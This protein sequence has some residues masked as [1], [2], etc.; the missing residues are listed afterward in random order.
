MTISESITT[1]RNEAERLN[2]DLQNMDDEDLIIR[3]LAH[4]E[5]DLEDEFNEIEPEIS[6]TY[7]EYYNNFHELKGK[8][9]I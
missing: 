1:L 6:M 3:A 8:D 7:E 4:L 9:A 5:S 2:L